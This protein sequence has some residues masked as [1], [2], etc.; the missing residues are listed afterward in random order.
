MKLLAYLSTIW[1]TLAAVLLLGY[2]MKWIPYWQALAYGL[3]IWGT[4]WWTFCVY[5]IDKTQAAR[6]G[7]RVSEQTL[8]MLEFLGGWPGAYFGQQTFRHKT[9]KISYLRVFY[10][11]IFCHLLMLGTAIS[12]SIQRRPVAE[13]TDQGQKSV[14]MLEAEPLMQAETLRVSPVS[15]RQN[16]GQNDVG[17]ETA[18][19]QTVSKSDDWKIQIVPA[20][21]N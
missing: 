5:G 11:M 7:R 9:A 19:K 21:N 20:G 2:M 3:L 10:L 13:S 18:P 16:N 6:K 1:L 8:H 12:L 15:I 4:S 14:S 17:L